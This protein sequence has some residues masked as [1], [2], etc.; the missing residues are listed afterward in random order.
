MSLRGEWIAAALGA[1][2]LYEVGRRGFEA[3]RS[4]ESSEERGEQRLAWVR[5]Q[6]AWVLRAVV[7]ADGIVDDREH[8]L[9]TEFLGHRFGPEFAS[10][11]AFGGT[12]PGIAGDDLRGLAS[13]LAAELSVPECETVLAWCCELALADGTLAPSERSA[14]EEI[15]RGLGI[16]RRELDRL[17][18]LARPREARG[19]TEPAGSADRARAVLGLDADA[20]PEAIRDRYRELVRVHH[21][22]RHEHL[23][24][25]AAREAAERFREIRSAYERL[26]T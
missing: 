6:T 10:Q 14:L 22:D 11:G 3:W 20:G 4:S 1:W 24:A 19:A 17:L 2:A 13:T 7:R 12:P 5:L 15:A 8:A 25:E 23:G 21:P 16:P 26:R 9:L 18:R